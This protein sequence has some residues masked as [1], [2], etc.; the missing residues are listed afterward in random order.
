M[1]DPL[2]RL[3]EELSQLPGIGPKSAQRLA[4]HVLKTPPEKVKRLITALIDAKKSL[5]FCNVCGS[6]TGEE[7]GVCHVCKNEKRKKQIICVVQEASDVVT[8]ERSKEYKGLYHVLHGVISPMDGIG[9]DDIRLKEL[10][11]RVQSDEIEEIIVATNPNVEGEATAL[12]IAN[13]LKPFNV[14]ISRLAYGLPVGGNL[15]YADDM[16]LSKALEGRHKL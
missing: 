8:L 11:Q 10:L 7:D 1:S 16:T 13:L 6:F 4:F 12:Y 3:I 14:N 2:N 15:D 9:P 5:K